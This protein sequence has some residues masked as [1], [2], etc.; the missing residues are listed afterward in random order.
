MARENAAHEYG[1]DKYAKYAVKPEILP[2][3]VVDKK[4]N[5]KEVPCTNNASCSTAA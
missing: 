3:D 5:W 4:K 2:L 1:G